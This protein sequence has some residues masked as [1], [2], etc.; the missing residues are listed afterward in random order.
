MGDFERLLDV[1]PRERLRD[2][3]RSRDVMAPKKLASVGEAATRDVGDAGDIGGDICPD[4]CDFC[5][6]TVF[7]RIGGGIGWLRDAILNTNV[8]QGRLTIVILCGRSS[9]FEA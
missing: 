8:Y 6:P 7:V 2:R 5:E 4:D 1:A 9:R 3:P